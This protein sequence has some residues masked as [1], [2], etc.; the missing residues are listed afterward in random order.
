[1]RFGCMVCLVFFLYMM[2]KLLLIDHIGGTENL[3]HST[4][5]MLIS[6]TPTPRHH[7][8]HHH[9]CSS[10]PTRQLR[11]GPQPTP[12]PLEI[13]D[14]FLIRATLQA[15]RFVVLGVGFLHFLRGQQVLAKGA[16]AVGVGD[17]HGVGFDVG[18]GMCL[19]GSCV[20][21]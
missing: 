15:E 17:V 21:G 12:I 7:I 9:H 18:Y 13:P 10:K 2:G 16:D 8:Y 5:T 19:I 6:G 1:M 11:P 4:P 20:V 3:Y 14:R